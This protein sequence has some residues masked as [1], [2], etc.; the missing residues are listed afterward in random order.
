[1][2]YYSE[3]RTKNLRLALEGEILDW[4]KVKTKKMF[5]CPAY[6]A[7]GKLFV[8]LV[9]NGIVITK[10]S[11]AELEALSSQVERIPFQAGKRTMKSWARISIMEPENELDRIVSFVRKSYE[12]A[13]KTS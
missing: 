12:S 3:Q 8:F 5:G 11:E 6:Q 9:T 2:Q 10:L 13:L 4:P 1:M 7:E